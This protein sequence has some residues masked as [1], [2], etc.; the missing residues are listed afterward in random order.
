LKVQFGLE[1]SNRTPGT[2]TWI[3][4]S[5]Y[6]GHVNLM[7]LESLN[8]REHL[9]DNRRKPQEKRS[10]QFGICGV[11]YKIESAEDLSV[12]T[13]SLA[14]NTINMRAV[15]TVLLAT[16]RCSRAFTTSTRRNRLQS[17]LN[18]PK[19]SDFPPIRSEIWLSDYV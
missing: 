2:A 1:A 9:D 10:E 19:W 12:S 15:R 17:P 11:S 3:Y 13:I 14:C 18:V 8:S 16:P 6:F 7:R 5:S 4:A